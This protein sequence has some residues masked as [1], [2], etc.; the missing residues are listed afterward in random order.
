MD[1][2][3]RR[4]PGLLRVLGGCAMLVANSGIAATERVNDIGPSASAYTGRGYMVLG[5]VP[6]VGASLSEPAEGCASGTI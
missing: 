1:Y 3:Q 5:G 6:P 2:L 4:S